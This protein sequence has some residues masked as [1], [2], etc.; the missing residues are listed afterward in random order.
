MNGGYV[1]SRHG[2][3]WRDCARG[4]LVSSNV[5]AF[6]EGWERTRRS[7]DLPELGHTTAVNTKKITNQTCKKG[8]RKSGHV[9][10]PDVMSVSKDEDFAQAD[11][12]GQCDFGVH[13][14]RES[15]CT[16]SLMMD[17]RWIAAPR[18]RSRPKLNPAAARDP[19]QSCSPANRSAR[20]AVTAGDTEKPPSSRHSLHGHG[21]ALQ[22]I[23]VHGERASNATRQCTLDFTVRNPGGKAEKLG[24]CQGSRLHVSWARSMQGPCVLG[25]PRAPGCGQA[26][27]V[28]SR[29]MHSQNGY[30]VGAVELVDVH[31]KRSR[32]QARYRLCFMN[33]LPAPVF[34]EDL[35]REI[36]ELSALSRRMGIPSL[37]LVARRVK[38]WCF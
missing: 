14:K 28:S 22:R 24:A 6:F 20:N 23:L 8:W 29:P 38:I 16:G 9:E 18:N 15:V 37:M 21:N 1:P 34:P 4:S 5:Y 25:G 2:R 32:P 12:D 11:A 10:V 26:A 36:F 3:Q 27:I 17:S 30:T 35:E 13:S 31:R 19:P 33:L 7:R